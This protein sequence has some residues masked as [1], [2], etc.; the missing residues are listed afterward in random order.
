MP[1][2]SD[3]QTWWS[4]LFIDGADPGLE[5][6]DGV[7]DAALTAALDPDTAPATDDLTSADSGGVAFDDLADDSGVYHHVGHPDFHDAVDHGDA[8]YI[9]AE[10]DHNGLADDTPYGIDDEVAHDASPYDAAGFDDSADEL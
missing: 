4:S 8:G 6:P 5:V 1:N 9:E 10:P 3:E 7:W 2:S